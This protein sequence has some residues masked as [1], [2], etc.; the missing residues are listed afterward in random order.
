MIVLAGEWV[1]ANLL[2]AA[3]F[4]VAVIGVIALGWYVMRGDRLNRLNEPSGPSASHADA[5]EPAD[6]HHQAH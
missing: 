2:F 3:A 6:S 5:G 1:N 4:L